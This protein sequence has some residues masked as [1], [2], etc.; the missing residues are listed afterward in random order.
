ML[1]IQNF[2]NDQGW[3]EEYKNTILKYVHGSD[4]FNEMQ[5]EFIQKDFLNKE[6]VLVSAKTATG[7]TLLATLCILK[8]FLNGEKSFIYLAP[9]S[10]LKEQ[11]YM[12]FCENLSEI[13]IKIGKDFKGLKSLSKGDLNLAISD[14]STFDRFLR[15]KK[16]FQ[17]ASFYVFDEIDV[18][19]SNYF[20]PSVEGSI[21]RLLRKGNFNLL[22]ISATIPEDNRLK[23]WLNAEFFKS[24]YQPIIPSEE[25]VIVKDNH[26]K[27]CDLFLKDE[28]IKDKSILIMIYHKKWAMDYARDI[29]EIFKNQGI[30]GLEDEVPFIT[31]IIGGA[32]K[33][34]MIKELINCLKFRVAFHHADLP[35]EIKNK[36]VDYYNNEQIKI[37]SCSPTLLRG[38]NLK[39]RTIIL[40][41][42]T[43][44]SVDLHRSV[45]ISFSDYQQCKGRA[46][47]P[48]LETEAFVFIFVKNDKQKRACEDWFLKGDLKGLKSGF[49]DINNMLRYSE[50]DKQILFEAQF[51]SI[52]IDV[53]LNILSKYYFAVGISNFSRISNRIKKRIKNLVKF[54][55]IDYDVDDQIV[56]TK[57][58]NEYLNVFEPQSISIRDLTSLVNLS[59][60]I[61]TDGIEFD[62][63]FHFKII[64]EILSILSTSI[65]IK[66]ESRGLERTEI[67]EKMKDLLKE[68]C[69][70]H[71]ETLNSRYITLVCLIKHLTHTSLENLDELFNIDSTRL[72]TVI[73]PLIEKYLGALKRI[74][75]F[76]INNTQEE[77][78]EDLEL[79]ENFTNKSVE[80]LEQFLDYLKYRIRYGVKFELVPIVTLR[81]IGHFKAISLYNK[82]N[83]RFKEKDYFDWTFISDF[84]E[85][86]K[87]NDITGWGPTSKSLLLDKFDGILSMENKIKNVLSEFG[88]DYNIKN[89]QQ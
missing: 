49:I 59:L 82:L 61:I 58:G 6:R 85:E 23:D 84:K 38:V 39:T 35:A 36:I 64:N 26:K 74:T 4:T 20:G 60:K 9:Y 50:L 51:K 29:V 63:R 34:K 10:S 57:F 2:I 11:K 65:Y 52:K 30:I 31:D 66:I 71:I 3:M 13:D 87:T 24:D 78:Y 73:K 41:Y 48:G 86:L 53:L 55:L 27:I 70:I 80:L 68:K 22:A 17:L 14:F 83:N 77:Y 42:T 7:K 12:E 16:D 89:I 45:P 5:S 47:R 67:E 72:D 33:T 75:K 37:I 88:I 62:D 28:K 8:R 44:Y 56:P 69:G 21:A 40:P 15:Y 25:V 32:Q 46:G 1:K 54:N 19:S 79:G 76:I 43:F 81:N 18:L